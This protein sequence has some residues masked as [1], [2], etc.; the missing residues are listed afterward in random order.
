MA[1]RSLYFISL[2]WLSLN[3]AQAATLTV[4]T[5]EDG[6]DAVG[7]G[8]CETVKGN[9]ICTLR[10]AL[11][12]SELT[13]EHDTIILPPGTY[14]LKPQPDR[15]SSILF[16]NSVTILGAGADKTI[17]DSTFYKDPVNGLPI[18]LFSARGG[19]A[20]GTVFTL[21]GLTI[22][23]GGSGN[24]TPFG[25]LGGVIW[26]GGAV[27]VV[28]EDSVIKNNE[29]TRVGGVIY[30][31]GTVTI[32]NSVITGNKAPV[33]GAIWNTGDMTIIN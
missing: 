19:S 28:I 16:H 14:Y 17:I 2:F 22:Q 4:N 5:L 20:S 8:V 31:Y 6:F 29:A 11:N 24:G 10:A 27:H 12:E 3:T 21:K 32:R 23:N 25:G 33:C 1:G 18:R 7:D 9:G 13:V 26:T 15:D 30:N